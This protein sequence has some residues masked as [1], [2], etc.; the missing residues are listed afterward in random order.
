MRGWVYGPDGAGV[1]GARIA[2]VNTDLDEVIRKRPV[3]VSTGEDGRYELA[4]E[5]PGDYVVIVNEGG[6][7]S[8]DEPYFRHYYTGTDARIPGKSLKL[9]PG[10]EINNIDI[11]LS[12]IFEVVTVS[13]RALY[14]D[15]EKIGGGILNYGSRPPGEMRSDG[16][17]LQIDAEGRFSLRAIKGAG[18]W[19]SPTYFL[20]CCRVKECDPSF[21]DKATLTRRPRFLT[22]RA[23]ASIIAD[24][25]ITGWE[26]RMPFKNCGK[27]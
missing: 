11:R 24:R 3:W 1:K 13:G 5:L 16:G 15:G 21:T 26:L 12:E 14:A 27:K 4:T 23:T 7:L 18:V 20:A 2:L 6:Y 9:G 19:I 22:K 17:D 8:P 10:V 25:D